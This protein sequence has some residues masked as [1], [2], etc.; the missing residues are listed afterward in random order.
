MVVKI[1]KR[2]NN[3]IGEPVVPSAAVLVSNDLIERQTGIKD[4]HGVVKKKPLT[5]R[6]KRAVSNFAKLGKKA[7]A[8]RNA[9]YPESMARNPKEVFD[10]PEV[11]AEMNTILEKLET[12]RNAILERMKITRDKA[13][14]GTLSMTLGIV[15][16]DIE[17]L[18]GRP[19]DRTKHELPDSEKEHLLKLLGKNK[20]K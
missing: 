18:S 11:K 1:I 5:P 19:T 15:N 10:K 13:N 16:K 12:E 2:G 20:K 4:F 6:E 14:Y 9:G 3:L 17:L 8:L 7:P